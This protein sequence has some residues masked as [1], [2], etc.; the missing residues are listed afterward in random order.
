[1]PSHCAISLMFCW[2]TVLPAAGEFPGYISNAIR[3]QDLPST[4]TVFEPVQY[5]SLDQWKKRRQ[6]YS[7]IGAE[8]VYK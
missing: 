5:P 4:H 7:Q 3:W 1:M 8:I 6:W 2:V